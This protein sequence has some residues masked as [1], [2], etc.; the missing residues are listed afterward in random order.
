[1]SANKARLSLIVLM[2]VLP[3]IFAQTASALVFYIPSSN[4]VYGNNNVGVIHVKIDTNNNHNPDKWIETYCVTENLLIYAGHTYQASM[5]S[6]P[7]TTVNREIAYILTWW[8]LPGTYIG[9]TDPGYKPASGFTKS[10]ATAIQNAIWKYT[11]HQSVSGT[12]KTIADDAYHKDVVDPTD[13]LTLTAIT[14]TATLA[15]LKAKLTTSGGQG[16]PNVLLIFKITG[17][18]S[19]TGLTATT[20]WNTPADYAYQGTTNSQGEITFTITFSNQPITQVDAYTKGIW[21]NVLDPYGCYQNLEPT[22]YKTTLVVKTAIFV[23]PEYPLAA[24]MAMAACFAGLFVFK[25]RNTLPNSKT[26]QFLHT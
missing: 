10:M 21:P 18:D 20:Q 23:V 5:Y 8:H 12:A 6:A 16:H 24:L 13:T 9:T 2:L 22:T 11:N 4:A 14:Q 25:K 7:D 19:V 17:T 26:S 15:T 1:M 3:F